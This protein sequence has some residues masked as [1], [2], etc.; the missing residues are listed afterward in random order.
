MPHTRARLAALREAD[1]MTTDEIDAEVDKYLDKR[2]QESQG[3]D[4]DGNPR[5]GRP[6]GT[7]P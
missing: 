7:A 4:S 3:A 5:T 1:K 2:A 6:Y